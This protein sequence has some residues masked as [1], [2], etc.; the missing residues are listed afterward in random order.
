M[1]WIFYIVACTFLL[2][3]NNRNELSKSEIKDVKKYLGCNTVNVFYENNCYF[4]KTNDSN[5][6]SDFVIKNRAS[7]VSLLLYKNIFSLNNSLNYNTSFGV[8]INSDTI[9]YKYSLSEI[10]STVKGEDVIEEVIS[11]LIANDSLPSELI[12][13]DKFILKNIEW[14]GVENVGFVGFEK[15]RVNI[16]NENIDA[17]LFRC[18]L[19]PFDRQVWF[20]YDAGKGKIITIVDPIKS[21]DKLE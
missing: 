20:Y 13:G 3:C 8:K 4:I 21:K 2:S 14:T 11:L 5:L 15:A 19:K 7:L 18:I 1:N 12:Y 6:K 17:I 9:T 16:Y 10:S